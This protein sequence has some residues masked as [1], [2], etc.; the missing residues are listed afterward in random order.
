MVETAAV[1]VSLP[2]EKGAIRNVGAI[3]VFSSRD[4]LCC[5]SLQ[6]K[7]GNQ[8]EESEAEIIRVYLQRK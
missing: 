5:E 2:R 7:K 8:Q 6:E 1:Y 4:S 3:L